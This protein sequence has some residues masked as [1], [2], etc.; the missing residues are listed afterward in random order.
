MSKIFTYLCALVVD[1]MSR[2]LACETSGSPLCVYPIRFH[3]SPISFMMAHDPP[4]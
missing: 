2:A 4:E 1:K 3:D